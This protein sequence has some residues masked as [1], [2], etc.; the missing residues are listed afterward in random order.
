VHLW[1]ERKI[2][3]SS[4]A[5][6]DQTERTMINRDVTAALCAIPAFADVAALVSA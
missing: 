5:H 4:E 2:P 6:I 3:Q 1:F